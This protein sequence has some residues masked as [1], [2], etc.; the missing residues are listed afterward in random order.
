MREIDHD[1]NSYVFDMDNQNYFVKDGSLRERERERVCVY[2][3]NQ[4]FCFE[5]AKGEV[6]QGQNIHLEVIKIQLVFKYH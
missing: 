5:C 2:V 6:D 4:E 1:D 3:V